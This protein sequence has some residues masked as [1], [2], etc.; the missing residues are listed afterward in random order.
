[1]KKKSEIIGKLELEVKKEHEEII[2]GKKVRVIDKA[3]LLSI[4]FDDDLRCS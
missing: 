1:M 4:S 2:D 3:N